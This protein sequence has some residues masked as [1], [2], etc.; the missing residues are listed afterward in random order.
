M[1][2]TLPQIKRMFKA[3]EQHS[4]A[5]RKQA[6][7]DFDFYSGPGQWTQAE[8]QWLND[9]TRVPVVFNRTA[10][11]INT[12]AGNEIQNREEITYSPVEE[13]DIR[14]N[15]VLNSAAQWFRK[16]AEAEDV[17]SEAFLDS[18]ICGLG[19]TETIIDYEEDPKGKPAMSPPH[20][21]EM[22]WD[23]SATRKGLRDRKRTWRIREM[24]VEDAADLMDIDLSKDPT[25]GFRLNASWVSKNED[26]T[27]HNQDRA[28]LYLDDAG[29]VDDL[30]YGKI[31][32]VQLQIKEK[33]KVYRVENP[34]TQE[35]LYLSPEENKKLQNR[36]RLLGQEPLLATMQT[37]W[38]YNQ[39]WIGQ[40]IL[41]PPAQ[42]PVDGFTLKFITGYR[43]R[44]AGTFFGMI[45]LMRDPQK[46]ANKWLSQI[47]HILDKTAKGGIMAER[48]A[49]E[50]EEEFK[51][52]WAKIDAVSWLEDGGMDRVKEKP[53]AKIPT[54]LFNLME[55]AIGSIREAS[56]VNLEMLGQRSAI[57]AASLE[58][59]RKE[60]GLTI[61]APVFDSLR[62]YRIDHGKMML[63]YIKRYLNDGRLIRIVGDGQAK[64]VP[65]ALKQDVSY[66]IT[67][68]ES[69]T[70]PH[71]KEKVWAFIMPM[72]G[73]LPP[74]I[75]AE[76][77]QFSPLPG[78]VV[79]KLQGLLRQMAQPDPAAEQMKQIGVA[80]G[81]ADVEMTKSAS[82]AQ[83]AEAMMKQSEVQGKQFK[84]QL[85]AQKQ[86]SDIDSQK[87]QN[88]I[89]L[90]GAQQNGQRNSE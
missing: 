40:D 87:F 81:Q 28:D 20:P 2:L 89:A 34:D 83:Q 86:K 76:L 16:V 45:S 84:Q 22:Y 69:P 61:L 36:L 49:V 43:D 39:Y 38:V 54:G 19:A 9:E 57:Q 55:F 78:S 77:L 15:E 67:V 44:N 18:L 25:A 24:T 4:A 68:D 58:G 90:I 1:T 17:E 35:I 27:P 46:W 52:S 31:T 23:C 62:A 32:L 50:D 73:E 48:G 14:P 42:L 53:L 33:I 3:D 79:D 85:D 5:W 75:I 13:G 12:V 70:S 29:Q 82:I 30:S 51:A 65:L 6:K 41:E 37:K 11:I 72:L 71:I 10:T 47:L 26:G 80:Q 74:P 60:A 63:D 59:Q 66:D 88:L 8:R 7:E 21:L 64:Y 56:G